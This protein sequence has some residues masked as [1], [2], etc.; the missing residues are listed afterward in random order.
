MQRKVNVYDEVDEEL[1]LEIKRELEKVEE[2]LEKAKLLGIVVDGWGILDYMR[3][4]VENSGYELILMWGEQGS[5]KSSLMLH[6]AY[7]L[8][9][10]WDK[11]LDAVCFTPQEV[12]QKAKALPPGRRYT[13]LLWDDVGV[14]FPATSYRTNIDVYEAVGKMIDAYRVMASVMIFTAPDIRRYPKVISDNGTIEMWVARLRLAPTVCW[15]EA[16]RNVKQPNFYDPRD[17]YF[18]KPRI[19]SG[20]HHFNVIPK[21]VWKEYW[22]RR[23]Q[24]GREAVEALEETIIKKHE[25]TA[26]EA[27]ITAPNGGGTERK[28]IKCSRCG[29]TFLTRKNIGEYTNC[30]KCGKQLRVTNEVLIRV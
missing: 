19:E 30:G 5:G 23:V 9:G 13:I 25:K 12:I 8:V 6:L 2:P 1:L 22:E 4:A 27:T 21:D 16:Y 10:D 14:H 28:L 7:K 24:L 20:F 18:K 17:I 15:Y 29:H 26:I 3:W 11:V